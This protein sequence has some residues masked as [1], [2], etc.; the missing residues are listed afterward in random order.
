[1]DFAKGRFCCGSH[2]APKITPVA[3]SQDRINSAFRSAL[4]RAQLQQAKRGF[5]HRRKVL[6]LALRW[7]VMPMLTE[8]ATELC[9]KPSQQRLNIGS[10]RKLSDQPRPFGIKCKLAV[11]FG[12]ACSSQDCENIADANHCRGHV[13]DRVPQHNSWERG[14]LCH[15]DVRVALAKNV[16]VSSQH[17]PR[18]ENPSKRV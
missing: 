8:F 11:S 1:M 6:L 17:D 16:I 4:W 14:H 5:R 15:N 18:C 7:L 10:C 3:N 13:G 9:K 12:N 2:L